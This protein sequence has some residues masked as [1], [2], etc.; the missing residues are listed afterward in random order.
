MAEGGAGEVGVPAVARDTPLWVHRPRVA[1]ERVAPPA[2]SEE[3]R[4][5]GSHGGAALQVE[6]EEER[7]FGRRTRGAAGGAARGAASGLLSKVAR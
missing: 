1:D 6:S 7:A 4:G 5:E 3:L 2:G